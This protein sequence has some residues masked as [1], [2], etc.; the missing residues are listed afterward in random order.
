M[1]TVSRVI[2][3]YS[4]VSEETRQRVEAAVEQLGYRPSTLARSLSQQRSYT[5]GI[6]TFGL[7]HAPTFPSE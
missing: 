2:N 5:L 4:Y 1:Q 6:V 3:K 7:K